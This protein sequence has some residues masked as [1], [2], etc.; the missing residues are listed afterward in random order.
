M[1]KPC[2]NSQAI[3]GTRREKMKQVQT[4]GRSFNPVSSS[5]EEHL[6]RIRN[7][8]RGGEGEEE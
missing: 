1:P 7:F 3:G 2:H 6:P 5:S 4:R 8:K